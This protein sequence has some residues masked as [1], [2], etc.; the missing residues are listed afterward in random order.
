MVKGILD[1]IVFFD[2]PIAVQA[3]IISEVHL[4]LFRAHVDSAIGKMQE[5]LT[6]YNIN[7]MI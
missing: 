5:N 6:K 1:G 7:T 2:V 3:F 4:L